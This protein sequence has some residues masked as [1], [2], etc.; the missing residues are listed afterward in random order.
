MGFG[1]IELGFRGRPEP[2]DCVGERQ[3]SGQ[4]FTRDSCFPLEVRME[5]A[6]GAGPND[7]SANHRPMS[8]LELFAQPDVAVSTVPTV[9]SVRA[10]LESLLAVLRVA[11]ELP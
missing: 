6:D 3:G 10:R 11:R 4:S 9:D 5:A 2:G 1:T 7:E 8:Q